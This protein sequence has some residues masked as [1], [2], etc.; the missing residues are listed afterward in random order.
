MLGL[1]VLLQTLVVAVS[2]PATSP[3]YRPLRVAAAGGDFPREGPAGGVA[4]AGGGPPGGGR[5]APGRP[6]A[7][8]DAPL[9]LAPAGPAPALGLRAHGRAPRRPPRRP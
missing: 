7:R 9:R 1:I 5:A 8:R 3:E 6:D 2:G 4:G